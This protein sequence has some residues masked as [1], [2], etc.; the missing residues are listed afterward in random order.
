VVSGPPFRNP[1]SEI[2]T[3]QSPLLARS[4]VT[5]LVIMDTP[6]AITRRRV[7]SGL[8]AGLV[9]VAAPRLFAATEK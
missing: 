2:L 6:T 1:K 7:I 5:A 4:K 8:G 3:V 9:A